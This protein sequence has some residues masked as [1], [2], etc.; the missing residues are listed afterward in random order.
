MKILLAGIVLIIVLGVGGLIYRNAIE[1]SNQPIAC[2]ADA[3]VCPDGTAVGRVGTTCNFPVCPPPNV[4]LAGTGLAFALPAGYVANDQGGADSTVLAMFVSPSLAT[5]TK[6]IVIH[7][8]PFTASTTDSTAALQIIQSTALGDA[9][10]IPVAPTAFTSTTLGTHHF[11]VVL[12]GRFE[13]VV[14]TVYYLVRTSD[15]LRFDAIDSGADWT[16]PALDTAK[17]PANQD[18]QALLTTLQGN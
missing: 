12:L 10:G 14:H 11:S 3:K 13:G 7:W 2:P 15:V 8:Y 16:N 4:T 1:H 5:T 17:L 9:S 18:V 6:S